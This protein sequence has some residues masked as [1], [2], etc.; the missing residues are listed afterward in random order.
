MTSAVHGGIHNV[1]RHVVGVGR[2]DV[3]SSIYELAIHSPNLCLPCLFTLEISYTRWTPIGMSC[4]KQIR[5]RV[6][7]PQQ[8]GPP[9]IPMSF[10]GG[11][12]WRCWDSA[13]T[14]LNFTALWVQKPSD[15]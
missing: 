9:H 10:V 7:G 4:R 12:L 5:L 14:L 1:S 15:Y 2:V 8:K 11:Q 13:D 6:A 3:M